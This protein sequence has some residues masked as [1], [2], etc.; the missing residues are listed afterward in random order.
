MPSIFPHV[1]YRT[2]EPTALTDT[3]KTLCYTVGDEGDD[4]SDVAG[5]QVT[6]AGAAMVY[7]KVST[8]GTER[9]FN[10]DV[11]ISAGYPHTIECFPLH[12][13][14]GGTISVEGV[15]GQ[16]VWITLIRGQQRG[17]DAQRDR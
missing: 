11:T 13:E 3:S 14:P 4:W 15:S 5:I 8:N 17:T 12:L 6:G 2:V 9:L 1:D 16:I 10:D 7:V